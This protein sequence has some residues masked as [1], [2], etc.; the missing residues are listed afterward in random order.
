MNG[1]ISDEYLLLIHDENGSKDYSLK[2]PGSKSIKDVKNDVYDLTLIPVRHQHWTGWPPNIDE[3][4]VSNIRAKIT[5]E[6]C[7]LSSHYLLTLRNSDKVSY[8][9]VFVIFI[10]PNAN[11]YVFTGDII[12]CWYWKATPSCCQKSC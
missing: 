3:E 7:A 8:C 5:G 4:K 10:V 6:K 2:F 9:I 11:Y 12:L 1:S